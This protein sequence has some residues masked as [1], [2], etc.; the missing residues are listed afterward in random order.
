[1]TIQKALLAVTTSKQQTE[2]ALKS[3][4]SGTWKADLRKQLIYQYRNKT[5]SR[6]CGQQNELPLDDF[7]ALI[8]PEDRQKV[9]SKW[10]LLDSS[11]NQNINLS[12]CF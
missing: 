2:M 11:K 3:T 9:A 10:A 6:E 4:K 8:H 12:I 7:I 5:T 1:M